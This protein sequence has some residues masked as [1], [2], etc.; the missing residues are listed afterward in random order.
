MIQCRRDYVQRDIKVW[1]LIQMLNT[2]FRKKI[3]YIIN[4][5]FKIIKKRILVDTYK[6][7]YAN[8]ALQKK[9]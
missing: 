8:L 2:P 9:K 5:Y 7:T 3:I 6:D 4:L 1:R